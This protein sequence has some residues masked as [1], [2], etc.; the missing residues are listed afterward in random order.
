MGSEVA[1][2][3][4]G[5]KRVLFF[6][7]ICE[8]LAALEKKNEQNSLDKSKHDLQQLVAK[9]DE[10]I[11]VL[12]VFFLVLFHFVIFFWT[13]RGVGEREGQLRKKISCFFGRTILKGS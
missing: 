1:A 10:Q 5:P 12:K 2:C 9:R 4:L 7:L 11:S 13:A 3:W 8:S 6:F